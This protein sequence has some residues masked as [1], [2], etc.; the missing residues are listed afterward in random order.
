MKELK[1]SI[2]R[3]YSRFVV[4]TAVVV[5]GAIAM[6]QAQKDPSDAATDEP[7]RL[8]AGTMGA[9]PIPVRAEPH[10]ADPMRPVPSGNGHDAAVV[11]ASVHGD[12]QHAMDEAP[13]LPGDWSTPST[14]PA[15]SGFAESYDDAPPPANSG[16]DAGF[17]S[18]DESAYGV[19]ADDI[20]GATALEYDA[21]SYDVGGYDAGGYDAGQEASAD[22]I[23]GSDAQPEH[24]PFAAAPPLLPDDM[25]QLQAAESDESAAARRNPYREQSG[26]NA[27]PSLPGTPPSDTHD[28]PPA[29]SALR[30]A[31]AVAEFRAASVRQRTTDRRGSS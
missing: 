15:D 21:P 8:L 7:P 25:S 29:T 18:S 20:S 9:A 23:A 22:A 31:A 10:A 2:K 5:F 28:D 27:P 17:E 3:I 1:K 16:Y 11:P 19:P 26:T 6:A 13:S 12:L 14:D 4:L 24:S 30:R